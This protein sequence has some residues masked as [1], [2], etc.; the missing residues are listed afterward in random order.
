MVPADAAPGRAF[1]LLAL[2][3]AA[4]A[5]RRAVRVAAARPRGCSG[6]ARGAAGRGAAL[7]AAASQAAG[8]RPRPPPRG[9]AR[10]SS[11]R[12]H[13][14][15]VQ[16]AQ[17][18][19]ATVVAR[20]S[21]H[22]RLPRRGRDHA[23]RRRPRRARRTRRPDRA[24]RR[25][26]P[27]APPWTGPGAS[28]V[29]A[30]RSPTAARRA[31]L[32]RLYLGDEAI[33]ADRRDGPRRWRAQEPAQ[34]RQ[35]RRAPWLQRRAARRRRASTPRRI[36]E[37]REV[38]GAGATER[39]TAASR[40]P[41]TT[42]S[43]SCCPTRSW[44]S[45]ATPTRACAA[46]CTSSRSSG[47]GGVAR[48]HAPRPRHAQRAHRL[49]R[50]AMRRG[51]SPS[52]ASTEFSLNF[53]AFGRWLRAPSNA[54]ERARRGCCASATAGSRSSACI[55]ST[56]SSSRAGS[57]ATCSFDR[58]LALPRVALAALWAEGQL[59]KPRPPLRRPSAASAQVVA[60]GW[61]LSRPARQDAAA[62]AGA[63][64]APGQRSAATRGAT[65]A[66]TPGR[67]SWRARF[68]A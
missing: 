35:P 37:L 31:G 40:W 64:S 11:R 34:G 57:R 32:R 38:S 47:A 51:C 30:R 6:S 52:A 5:R 10:P 19:A 43:T 26:R 29:P 18:R 1:A 24:R 39:P 25:R 46:S 56:R 21:C 12:G 20:R 7:R 27:R 14:E 22:G 44:C 49:P 61:A 68:Q 54:L 41:T 28:S 17:R 65:D 15:R 4:R 53:A 3:T 23:R 8:R 36:A 48:L 33:L 9:R 2:N 45:R 66:C 50:R 13:P 67:R 62:P 63:A 16:A 60:A 58:P 42:S 55:A 59:P